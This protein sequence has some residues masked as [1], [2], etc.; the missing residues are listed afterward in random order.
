MSSNQGGGLSSGD[1]LCTTLYRLVTKCF[2]FAASNTNSGNEAQ[3]ATQQATQAHAE[4]PAPSN[5]E[6]QPIQ[7][8]AWQQPAPAKV[9]QPPSK[10]IKP[11]ANLPS[12]STFTSADSSLSLSDAAQKLWH[13]DSNRLTPCVDYV[14]NVQRGKKPY[15]KTDTA[16]DPL[17]TSINKSVWTRPTYSAFHKLLDNYKFETGGTEIISG[18]HKTEIQQFL[19][20]IMATGP[21]QFCHAYCHAK[22]PNVI[23]KDSQEFTKLLHKIWFD[24]YRRDGH[25]DSSGF[26][27]VFVGEVQDGQ[28]SGFHNWIQFALQEEKGALDYRG[29]IKPKSSSDAMADSNDHL[30]T[31]QFQWNGVEK[32]V[33]TSFI[34]TSPEFEFALYTMCFLVGEQDN[35]IELHTGTDSFGVLIKCYKMAHDKIGTTYP[36]VTSHHEE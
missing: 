10:P 5:T 30:L 7:P 17:F 13:L 21:M 24:L 26:E 29:Y 25:A 27:H 18:E 3:H 35:Q 6:E 1:D 19:A 8:S 36:E 23:P 22:N 34:G 28:V 11:S 14:L 2:A 20:C 12:T 31:L 16:P 15:N 4:G 32:F 33:G 9:N